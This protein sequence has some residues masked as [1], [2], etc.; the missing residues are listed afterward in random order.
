LDNQPRSA[1]GDQI[2]TIFSGAAIS[3]YPIKPENGKSF[4][5]GA[6]YDPEWLSGLS[7]SADYWRVYLLNNITR[8]LGQLIVDFCY[9][10]GSFDPNNPY[11][12]AIVFTPTGSIDTLE[13]PYTSIQNLGRLDASGVD[14]AVNYRLPELAFGNFN[15]GLN[16]TYLTEYDNQVPGAPR[17]SVAGTFNNQYGNFPRWRAL[18]NVGWQMGDFSAN[19]QMRYIGHLKN[20]AGAF[21]GLPDGHLPIGSVT[22]HNASFGYNIQPINTRIDVGVD[23]IGDK[24]PPYFYQSVTNANIDINTYDPI[25]RYY[26]GRVTVKF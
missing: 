19:W 11:C 16:A 26:W 20:T 5:F 7:V 1:S 9:Q 25:G 10:S 3:G 6:V 8:P 15:V 13:G 23:N 14:I 24:Q 22:Y 21:A 12:Q 18:G 2:Q 4:N 17:D